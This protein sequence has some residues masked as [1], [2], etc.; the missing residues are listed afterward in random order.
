[1]FNKAM[2][3]IVDSGFVKGWFSWIEWITLTAVLIALG[4]QFNYD[5][6]FFAGILSICLCLC[7]SFDIKC[8]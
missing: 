7:D 6:L 2:N 5:S 3:L 8:N 4:L 1:M